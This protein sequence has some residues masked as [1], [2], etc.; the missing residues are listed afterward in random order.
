[1][2]PLHQN[3]IYLIMLVFRHVR[4]GFHT[5]P[6]Y[7]RNCVETKCRHHVTLIKSRLS[8]RLVDGFEDALGVEVKIYWTL[9]TVLNILKPQNILAG[10]RIL[11]PHGL[12]L[13]ATFLVLVQKALSTEMVQTVVTDEYTSTL[14]VTL[15]LS[16]DQTRH[17]G[18]GATVALP[19]LVLEEE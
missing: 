5:K 1:M 16:R 18:D 11:C 13:Q 10:V 17:V 14:V 4:D 2:L 9:Q 7:A 6:L 15:N 19:V 3:P 12:V 8:A